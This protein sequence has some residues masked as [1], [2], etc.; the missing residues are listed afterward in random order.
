[1]AEVGMGPRA[2]NDAHRS[3]VIGQKLDLLVIQV[4]PVNHQGRIHGLK[5]A[6][7]IQ[8]P[9]PR[10]QHF[11]G[12]V[13]QPTQETAE[14]GRCPNGGIRVL[15]AIRPGASQWANAARRRRRLP[16]RSARDARCRAHEGSIPVPNHTRLPRER[17]DAA[18]SPST[19]LRIW[20]GVGVI[21]SMKTVRRGISGQSGPGFQSGCAIS[22]SVVV[23][24]ARLSCNPSS[25][26][27][28]RSGVAR[29]RAAIT[30]RIQSTKPMP[31]VPSG[32]VKS[33]NSRCVCALTKPGRMAALPRSTTSARASL[34]HRDNPIALDHHGP[35]R[36]RWSGHRKHIPR[37]EQ[38]ARRMVRCPGNHVR[39][40]HSK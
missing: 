6:E 9:R 28:T 17:L 12:P 3:P 18:R 39:D 29:R 31:A 26:A 7:V 40:A 25:T 1:M 35:I 38:P 4:V 13:G 11:R 23:P 20:S 24:Q 37:L 10:F 34:A 8:R 19:T 21:N 33:L 2:V 30:A 36:N 15:R 14:T 5:L 32:L 16:G 22:P 27:R